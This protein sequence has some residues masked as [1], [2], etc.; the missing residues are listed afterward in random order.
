MR[1]YLLEGRVV[2]P[3]LLLSQLETLLPATLLGAA[4]DI[5]EEVLVAFG[6]WNLSI[7]ENSL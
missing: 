1:T 3:L 2:L 5:V 6:V 7:I 4:I